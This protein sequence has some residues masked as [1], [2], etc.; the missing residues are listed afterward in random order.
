MNLET[1]TQAFYCA[2]RKERGLL[3][4]AI[5]VIHWIKLLR[6]DSTRGDMRVLLFARV[7]GRKKRWGKHSLLEK[8]VSRSSL[9]I[10]QCAPGEGNSLQKQE[11]AG[12]VGTREA[13]MAPE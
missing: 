11:R 1:A 12:R 7:R 2:G 10:D 8:R 13:E 4:S 5:T 3:G 9:P 6:Q